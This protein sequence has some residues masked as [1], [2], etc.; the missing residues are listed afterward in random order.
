MAEWDDYS[1]YVVHFTKATA[2]STAYQN[3]LSICGQRRLIAGGRFG[4]ARSS[5][6]VH[7]TQNAV[8]FSEVPL[9]RLD[10]IADRRSRYGLGFT[11]GFARGLGVVPVWYVEKGSGPAVSLQ[12]MIEDALGHAR[13]EEQLIWSVTP[14]IDSPG[15]YP[16]GNYRF[17]WER[18]W[19]CI[20][21]FEFSESDVAF[22]VI[23]EDL[24]VTAREF[25]R[26]AREDNIGPCYDCPY[27][28]SSWDSARVAH[29][30][31]CGWPP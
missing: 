9:G 19:R 31:G 6:P 12:L 20:G 16:T 1:D 8:C 15:S 18:E 24:H 23:P 11:K 28:D 2:S 29:A 3:A 5:A 14:F 10:R 13:P 27:I 4:I 30:L 22:L 7:K 21:D 25:F 26:A 17:E